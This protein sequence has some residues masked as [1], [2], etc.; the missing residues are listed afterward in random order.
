M[1]HAFEFDR[2]EALVDF[3]AW[4]FRI[5]ASPQPLGISSYAQVEVQ[6]LGA[7]LHDLAQEGKISRGFPQMS[8]FGGGLW[9][10]LYEGESETTTEFSSPQ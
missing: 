1:R 10:T 9:L 6:G 3:D 4:T 5:R 8:G 7:L 2:V